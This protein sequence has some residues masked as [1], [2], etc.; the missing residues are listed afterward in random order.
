M[1]DLKKAL[2]F[3]DENFLVGLSNKGTYKRACKDIDCETPDFDIKGETAEVRTGGEVCTITVP[4]AESKCTCVSRGICRHIVGAIITLRNNTEMLEEA[5]IENKKTEDIPDRLKSEIVSADENFLVSLSNKGT[6]KRAC[7][8]VDSETPDFE[9]KGETAEVRTG[10]EVCTI[11]VPLAESKCTCVSRGICR[12]IV[13]AI[14]I[15][16]NN[17]DLKATPVSIPVQQEVKVA[18]TVV[19]EPP[20]EFLSERDT[21]KI[22]SCVRQCLETLGSIIKYGLVRIPESLPDML[23]ASAVRCHSLKM[24]DAERVLRETGSRL[25]ECISRRAS[26]SMTGFINEICYCTRL[27]ADLTEEKLRPEKLGTFRQ[28]Y[29]NY[30]KKLTILPIGQRSMHGDYAGE[31]YYFLNIDPYAEQRFFS[32]SD[33]RP[34]FY[35]NRQK[36]FKGNS[37]IWGMDVPI[38]NMMHSEMVLANAKVNGGKLSTSQETTV[39]ASYDVVIDCDE[40]RDLIYTDF[41]QLAVEISEKHPKTELDKMCFVQPEKCIESAFDKYLQQ[42]VIT[43]EDINGNRISVRAKY[44]AENKD[45]IELLESIGRKMLDKPK[46]NYVFLATAYVYDGELTLFPIE[47]YD[48]IR[49]KHSDPYELPE[50]YG[51]IEVSAVY[52]EKILDFFNE[53]TDKITVIVRSGL[54]A[55]IKNDHRLENLAFNYGLKG[56]SC[57]I[58][59]FM[60]S[61]SSYRHSTESDSTEVLLK[62]RTISDYIRQGRKRLEIITSISN[63]KGNN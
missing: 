47:V 25:S 42:Y 14:I 8:D 7:K 58:G 17:M 39:L 44:S 18:E 19:E 29:V 62:M 16:R 11:T 43:L 20:E 26:F 40:V 59:D 30:G 46:K 23:E 38:K 50:K 35:D 13:G 37:F 60:E 33:V 28:T 52:A 63:M 31:V 27:L 34:V 32:I 61:A 5:P 48:F 51:N 9:I 12:H 41:R 24:A 15:L 3:A 4:I 54:Q 1:E 55:D 22:H 45:F 53:V 56:L 21:A 2:L 6:Y 49:K 10:G 36:Y 57:I